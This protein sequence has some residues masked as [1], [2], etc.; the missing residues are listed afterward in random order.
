MCFKRKISY[1]SLFSLWASSYNLLEECL[2][3]NRKFS[4][5]LEF[6]LFFI[7]EV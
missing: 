1:K 5:L 6:D 3:R 7:F 2:T 4:K